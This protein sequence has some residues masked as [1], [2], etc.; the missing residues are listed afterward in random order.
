[1]DDGTFDTTDSAEKAAGGIRIRGTALRYRTR[2]ES[3]G[4]RSDAQKFDDPCNIQ[5]IKVGICALPLRL[6]L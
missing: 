6:Q 2:C 1:M 5:S 3:N 4:N